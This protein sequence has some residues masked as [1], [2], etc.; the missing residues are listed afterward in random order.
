M[1]FTRAFTYAFADRDWPV[2]LLILAALTVLAAAL[3]LPLVGLVLWAVLLGYQA[4]IV[5][6]VRAGLPRPLPRWDNVGRLLNNGLQVLGGVMVYNI[7]NFLLSGCIAVMS[8]SF[9]QSITGSAVSLGLA[10]CVLPLALVYN[11]IALPMQAL[12]LARY[13]ERNQIG[14]FFE[15][16]R[17]FK[18]VRSH[19]DL[20]I[21]FALWSLLATIVFALLLFLP[22]PFLWAPVHGFLMGQ[23]AAQVLGRPQRTVNP[24]QRSPGP[25]L[26][27]HR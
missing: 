20:S 16:P 10:C 13:G 11:G 5:R 8:P 19:L 12:A 2:K 23:Y 25:S 17:L 26:S 14:V 18:A 22:A 3:T 1:D 4:D 6:N 15:F 21:Q 7:P 9:S 27:R 24:Q